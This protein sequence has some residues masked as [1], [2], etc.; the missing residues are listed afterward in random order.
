M[1]LHKNKKLISSSKPHLHSGQEK[2]SAWSAEERNLCVLIS[3]IPSL[4][5]TK[6]SFSALLA[7]QWKYGASECSNSNKR[8]TA[9]LSP[10]WILSSHPCF[11]RSEIR[12]LKTRRNSFSKDT[13]KP[14]HI[15]YTLINP[16]VFKPT[17]HQVDKCSRYPALLS[18]VV[19]TY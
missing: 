13:Q 15:M 14:V 1:A 10:S 16:H 19:Y 17:H 3:E 11:Q 5:L 8:Y 12:S 7:T 4:N 9:Y 6:K 2:S 18:A